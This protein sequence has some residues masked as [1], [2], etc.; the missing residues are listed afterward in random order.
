M[1]GRKYKLA[2]RKFAQVTTDLGTSYNDVV[3]AQ[4]VATYGT[5]CALATF[6]RSELQRLILSSPTFRSFFELVPEIRELVH[7]FFNTRYASMLA[8]MNKLK[9][10]PKLTVELLPS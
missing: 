5:L 9:V 3:A 8:S 7:D 6:D 10:Q 1:E 4:D 2:A